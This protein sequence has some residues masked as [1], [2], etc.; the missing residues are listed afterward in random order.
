MRKQAVIFVLI[1]M[2]L[3]TGI[4]AGCGAGTPSGS[5][6]S[7][8]SPS[9]GSDTDA[10]KPFVDTG[11]PAGGTHAN[12]TAANDQSDS[13]IPDTDESAVD[14]WG[15]A[16]A[17]NDSDGTGT[18]TDSTA[19]GADAFS[20]VIVDREDIFFAIKEVRADAALGYTWKVYLEN[21]TD[22]NLMFSFEKVSLNN[23]MCDPFWAEVITGGRKGNCEIT[24][25]RDAL[26][27]RQIADVN[28]VC[29]TLNVYNDEDYTEA[30]L[31]HDSFTVYPT[32]GSSSAQTG[33][34]DGSESADGSGST[35]R[36]VK[37]YPAWAP[38]ESD[39]VLVDNDKCLIA[40]TGYD[41]DNT[42]GFA[43]RMCL[44][45]KSDEDLVF[46]AENTSINGIMCDP[47]WA[48]IVTAGK[49]AISTILWDKASLN[50][51]DITDVR[52]ITLPIRVYSDK[53]V[54][55]PY[56]DETFELE[57]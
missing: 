16:K 9:G 42:W 29:F 46:S 50:E 11:T 47:Y 49:S 6:D 14:G 56:V 39:K 8:A 13:P 41:P 4:C 30:P 36:S 3:I 52:E 35:D 21:R 27:E 53:N 1:F 44:I 32:G 12:D 19:P 2:F 5:S 40:L 57:P 24:W 55:E 31:I 7:S 20:R 22:K 34:A 43:A 54:Y 38:S 48:E 25:M 23:I 51:N 26:E 17:D 33:T 37:T 10:D 45:N 18:G 28:E 15:V